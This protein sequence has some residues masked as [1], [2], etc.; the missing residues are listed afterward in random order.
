M[1]LSAPEPEVVDDREL[2]AVKAQLEIYKQLYN[3]LLQRTL[4]SAG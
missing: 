2:I 3:D 1:E 4:G